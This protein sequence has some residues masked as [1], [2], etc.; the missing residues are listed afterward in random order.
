M[1][2]LSKL[3]APALSRMVKNVFQPQTRKCHGV[4]GI[5]DMLQQEKVLKKLVSIL[6]ITYTYY[7]NVCEDGGMFVTLS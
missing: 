7:Y 1:F 6:P 3:R 4:F 2:Q 5:M